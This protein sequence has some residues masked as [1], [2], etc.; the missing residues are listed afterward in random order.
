MRGMRIVNWLLTR[1][2]QHQLWALRSAMA[3]PLF[4]LL[5]I[6]T[7]LLWVAWPWLLLVTLLTVY[8]PGPLPQ[9]VGWV[10]L[11]LMGVSVLVACWHGVWWAISIA[12]LFG[13]R[14]QAA[15]MERVLL[16]RLEK[17]QEARASDG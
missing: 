5:S 16:T 11:A 15:Y 2:T 1:F 10:V 17:L 12:L 3:L 6:P 9:V 7:L 13:R 14:W 4:G 8:E